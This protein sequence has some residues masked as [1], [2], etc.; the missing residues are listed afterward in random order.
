MMLTFPIATD[1]KNLTGAAL[2]K[3]MADK[4]KKTS[5]Y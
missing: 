4:Q 5:L 2:T 3:E 1:V